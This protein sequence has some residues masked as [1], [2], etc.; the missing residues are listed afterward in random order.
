MIRSTAVMLSLAMLGAATYANAQ[1]W[2]DRQ[3]RRDR[4]AIAREQGVPP[5]HLPPANLCR[6][7]YDNRPNGQQPAA[8]NC[9]EAELI[10]SRNGQARV[11][12]GENVYSGYPNRYPDRAVDRGRDV[13]RV[14]DR[15]RDPYGDRVRYTTPAFQ[16]GYRDGLDK[17][18]DDGD[19][20]DRFDVTRHDWYR[21]ATRGYENEYGSRSSYQTMYREGFEAGYADG[22]RAADRR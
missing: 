12:Y 4:R 2:G 15:N 16:N 6:V 10:A 21:S 5:G 13:Y 8:T 11:I 3:D 19:D 9:R 14:P 7:W 22:Y 1:V 17:G 20:N 18:R